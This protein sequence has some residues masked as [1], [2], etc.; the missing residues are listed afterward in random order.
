M[1]VIIEKLPLDWND[2]NNYLK[3]KR[4]KMLVEYLIVKLRI[5]KDNRGTEKRLNKA[6]N[7]NDARTSI[8]EVKDF[9]KGKQL[10]SGFKLELKGGVSKKQKF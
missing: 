5:E 8:I 3:H 6:T 2:F 7:V 10:Q 9:K 1:A 4:K